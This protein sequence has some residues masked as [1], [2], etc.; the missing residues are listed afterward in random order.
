MVT[1]DWWLGW[2]AE[3]PGANAQEK[4]KEDL[5]ISLR[6]AA[7]DILELHCMEARKEARNDFE[8]IALMI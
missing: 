4:T 7:R 8:E 1:G 3:I 6:E 2:V 5:V